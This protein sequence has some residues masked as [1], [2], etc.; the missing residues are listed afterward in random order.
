MRLELVLLATLSTDIK[1]VLKTH[2]RTAVA[3]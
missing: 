1:A 3:T 2:V